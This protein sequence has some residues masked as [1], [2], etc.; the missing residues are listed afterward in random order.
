MPV[1]NP[2]MTTFLTSLMV[3]EL[4]VAI[5]PGTKVTL[6]TGEVCPTDVVEESCFC[7]SAVTT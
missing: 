6:L 1:V 4:G 5:V 2:L 7:V 3:C